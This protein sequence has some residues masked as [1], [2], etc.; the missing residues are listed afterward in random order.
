MSLP[1]VRLDANIG[2][3]DKVLALLAEKDGARA[4]VLY[5]CSLGYCGAH[6]TDGLVKKHTLTV[7]HGTEKLAAMLV[8]QGL[9]EYDAGGGGHYRVRN[10]DT[11]QQ[12]TLVSEAKRAAQQL[13]A[14]RTNCERWHGAE[15]GCW[16]GDAK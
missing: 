14:K 8:D 3:N 6:G 4:F 5:V 15:C 16:R 9:W 13:A 11:R 12:S 2:T 7:N 10:W 1:W